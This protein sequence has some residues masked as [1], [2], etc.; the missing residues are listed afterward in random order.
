MASYYGSNK[1]SPWA[2]SSIHFNSLKDRPAFQR[3]YKALN[4]SGILLD[5]V[6]SQTLVKAASA[7]E[8]NRGNSPSATTYHAT[9]YL[10]GVVFV[11]ADSSF[12]GGH[13]KDEDGNILMT[14]IATNKGPFFIAFDTPVK[15]TENSALEYHKLQYRANTYCTP[16]YITT[17]KKYSVTLAGTNTPSVI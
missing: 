6:T 2:A 12:A 13:I 14:P 9:H 4:S 8:I 1:P 11:T 5:N 17:R 3:E 16:L 7:T 15:V 10:W